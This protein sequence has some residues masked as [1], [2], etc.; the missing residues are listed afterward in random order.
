LQK[1]EILRLRLG[2]ASYKFR[3][4]QTTIPLADL[5]R[6]PIP[7]RVMRQEE[8]KQDGEKMGEEEREQGGEDDAEERAEGQKA[9]D[10]PVEER[11]RS[12]AE[13]G[14]ETRVSE[15]RQLVDKAGAATELLGL[16]PSP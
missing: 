7:A 8:E 4:G 3:T 12:P 10:V 1:A 6:R 9:A 2:L 11:S 5:Q 14:H 16:G 13:T 15:E